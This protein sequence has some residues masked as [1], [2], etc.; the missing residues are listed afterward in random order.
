MESRAEQ[1]ESF[2]RELHTLFQQRSSLPDPTLLASL[3]QVAVAALSAENPEKRPYAESDRGKLPGGL[4][5]LF[6]PHVLLIPDLHAR[7][8][9]LSAVLTASIHAEGLWDESR[10]LLDCMDAGLLEIVCLGDILHGESPESARNWVL[11]AEKY[12]KDGRDESLLS[13]EMDAEM[14]ASVATLML[15]MKIKALFPDSFHSLKGNHDNMSNSSSDG[16]FAF[17]KYAREG[18][19]GAAWFRLRYGDELMKQMRA[20]E[21][22]LPLVAA[23][24]WF[25]ASHAEPRRAISA[26]DLLNYRE[27]PDVVTDLIWTANGNAEED[28]VRQSLANLI[29]SGKVLNREGLWFSGHRP[30]ISHYALRQNGALVQIHSQTRDQVVLLNNSPVSAEPGASHKSGTING[31]GVPKAVFLELDKK[32]L[33]S[34]AVLS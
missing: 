10:T 21:R 28:S 3:L 25:C 16:D 1:A 33:V 2:I 8:S 22:L 27:R 4:V 18:A 24:R 34:S 15:V 30:V 13:S 14:G 5:R 23:G 11:A 20:Y 9:F 29:S 7:F 6:A 26:E 17:Y 31:S 12:A 19:M 32:R